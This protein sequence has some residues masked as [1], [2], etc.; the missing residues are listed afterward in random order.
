MKKA[1]K[2]NYKSKSTGIKP[3]RADIQRLAKGPSSLTDYSK[4]SPMMNPDDET[5]L[6][7]GPQPPMF[8]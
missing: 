8:R 4:Q 5:T 6:F 2:F 1:K 3:G 7:A